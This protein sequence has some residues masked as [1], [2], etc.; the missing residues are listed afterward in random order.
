MGFILHVT[1]DVSIYRY[2]WALSQAMLDLLTSPPRRPL[3]PI[4]GFLVSLQKCP[5]SCHCEVI[6]RVA[7]ALGLSFVS[8]E[9]T[10]PWAP[11]AS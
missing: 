2:S 8:M 7:I 5:L 10:G 6:V 3:H 4:Q 9:Q 1:Q 11:L